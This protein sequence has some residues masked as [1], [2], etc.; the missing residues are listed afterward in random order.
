M[1]VTQVTAGPVSTFVQPGLAGQPAAPVSPVAPTPVT[2]NLTQDLEN[3]AQ[4]FGALSTSLTQLG[5]AQVAEQEQEFRQQQYTKSLRKEAE[6]EQRRKEAEARRIA[7]EAEA[8]EKE[9]KRLERQK[10]A[11][12]LAE[13]ARLRAEAS[14]LRTAAN[15]MVPVRRRQTPEETM[16][17]AVESLNEAASK[18][19]IPEYSDLPHKNRAISIASSATATDEIYKQDVDSMIKLIDEDPAFRSLENF[20]KWY[21]NETKALLELTSKYPDPGA[22]YRTTQQRREFYR[23]RLLEEWGTRTRQAQLASEAAKYNVDISNLVDEGFQEANKDGRSVEFVNGKLVEKPADPSFTERVFQTTLKN[24]QSTLSSAGV[25]GIMSRTDVNQQFG[26]SLVDFANNSAT[27][28]PR[29]AEFAIKLLKELKTGKE[30]KDSLFKIAEVEN[31]YLERRDE[32]ERKIKASDST[33]QSQRLNTFVEQQKEATDTFVYGTL[34]KKIETSL[35]EGVVSDKALTDIIVESAAEQGDVIVRGNN[36]VFRSE[37]KH[38]GVGDKTYNAETLIKAAKTRLL[39]SAM[40]AEAQFVQLHSTPPQKTL[41]PVGLGTRPSSDL[42][43][44]EETSGVS[45]Y[46]E[47]Y[48]FLNEI[49]DPTLKQQLVDVLARGRAIVKYPHIYSDDNVIKDFFDKVVDMQSEVPDEKQLGSL[50]TALTLV[51]EFRVK[52]SNDK[53]TDRI[54]GSNKDLYAA[55]E[56]LT[57]NDDPLLQRSGG[58]LN[59]QAALGSGVLSEENRAA[60]YAANSDEV[61]AALNSHSGQATILSLYQAS[62]G[63][64][65]LFAEPLRARQQARN[66]LHVYKMMNPTAD[67]DDA[68]AKIIGHMTQSSIVVNGRYHYKED[69]APTILSGNDPR[70]AVSPEEADRSLPVGFNGSVNKKPAPTLSLEEALQR[71]TDFIRARF[72]GDG[73][74]IMPGPNEEA[75]ALFAEMLQN[76]PLES[77]QRSNMF[78]RSGTG[79]D[80]KFSVTGRN[81]VDLYFAPKPGSQGEVFWLYAPDG[82]DNY[83]PVM[84]DKNSMDPNSLN[85]SLDEIMTL[86]KA[87][88][89]ED[90][91]YLTEQE[92]IRL[93]TL[94]KAT[95]FATSRLKWAEK[96]KNPQDRKGPYEQ[97]AITMLDNA[98]KKYVDENID[99][100][101]VP[102]DTLP[103]FSLQGMAEGT[104]RYK[105]MSVLRKEF[106]KLVLKGKYAQTVGDPEN[107]EKFGVKIR[108]IEREAKSLREELNKPVEMDNL[109][110]KRI[111]NMLDENVFSPA[112][113][114]IR[115]IPVNVGDESLDSIKRKSAKILDKNVTGESRTL[116]VIDN[117]IESLNKLPLVSSESGKRVITDVEDLDMRSYEQ[118]AVQAFNQIERIDREIQRIQEQRFSYSD[119]IRKAQVENLLLSV[120]VRAI[121]DLGVVFKFFDANPQI[122]E[123]GK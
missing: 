66:R 40:S 75:D 28:H 71:S 79:E 22:A 118:A 48:K 86:A 33:A 77:W 68:A 58:L 115:K 19:M 81:R 18:G 102:M 65:A 57:E 98:E 108:D 120:R 121:E 53:F 96:F 9:A 94:E 3:L 106:E 20:N 83:S 24:I 37:Y 84:R 1:P 93:E 123:E 43:W 12:A 107:L 104:R 49:E 119:R 34:V 72:H 27:V 41:S 117:A 91:Q 78:S 60:A 88:P 59:V 113:K 36:L 17:S 39:Q 35:K 55:I 114:Q 4:S 46:Y 15:E 25:E 110:K 122:K 5:R 47:T 32:I 56:V 62:P 116:Q 89:G 103:N 44:V 2:P 21:D 99:Q 45:P 8:K 7:N 52:D 63:S 105:R 111:Q 67:L 51:K 90:E 80:M 29:K 13:A 70:M 31:Y 6:A 11:D 64:L 16:R 14:R 109:F 97:M 101:T 87:I 61:E 95:P 85:W 50:K 42:D 73:Y 76:M 112:Q 26:R 38:L 23:N 100:K 92:D 10:K 74:Y 82:L 54:L 69:V 30:G